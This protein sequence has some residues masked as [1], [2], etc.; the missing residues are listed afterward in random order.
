[1]DLAYT[2]V[3]FGKPEAKTFDFKPPKGTKVT[4]AEPHRKPGGEAKGKRPDLSGFDIVNKD[5]SDWNKVVELDGGLPGGVGGKGG[6]GGKGGGSGD[7]QKMLDSFTDEAKGDFGTG[8]V[9]HTR[10]L[11][12]LMTDDG[13][14][15]VGAVTKEGLVKAANAAA[16]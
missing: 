16:K 5:A 9:F 7:G 11:N 15:Y 12:A 6:P 13:K 14:V 2:K 10:L 8:R 3:D 4:E 1:M